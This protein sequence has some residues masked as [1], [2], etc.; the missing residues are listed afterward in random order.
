M[1]VSLSMLAGAGAQF[2]TDSGVPL[3]GGL[4][5][6]YL[7]GSTTPT[8]TWADNSGVTANANPIVLDAGGRV[9][10]EIWLTPGTDYK[11]VL[12]TSTGVQIWSK[13][14][15]PG[16]STDS[17]DLTFLQAGTGA[18]TRTVQSKLRDTVSVMD[19]GAVGDGVTDDTAAINAA[20]AASDDVF[21][22]AG[23]YKITST[24]S[25]PQRKSLRGV[26]YKSRLAATIASGAVISITSG[27]GPTEVSGFRITGTATTGVSVNN[28]QTLIVDNISLDG[29]TATDGFVFVSSW[30]SV[31][32]NL[33]TNGATLSDSCFTCGQDFNANDCRN[34]YA[35]NR[36]TYNV[37]IDGAYNGGSGV[38]HGST[39]T[40]LCVQSGL[41]GIY[42][43]SYQGGTVNGVYSEDVVFPLRLGVASTK[44]ARGMRF[45]GGDFGGPYNTHPSYSSREAVLW[46]DYA[47]GCSVDGIDLSGAYNCGNAAPITFSGGGGSGAFAIARVTAAGVVQSVEVLCGG[48]GYTSDP[49]ASVGGS[50][51]GA[52]LTVTRVGNS[53]STIAVSTAGSGYIASNCP[54]AVT[55]NRAFKC[56]V[57]SAM[58]NSSFGDSSPL[59][60]WFVRRSGANSGAGITLQNDTSWRNSANGNAAMMLKTRSNNY[61]HVLL[62]WD[63]LG[64]AQ[65]YVYT[66]PQYP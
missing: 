34:W 58:F 23:T 12:K 3:A 48:T 10:A 21:V 60:P 50:G 17:A 63:N 64:A 36:C 20:L 45:N 66:P 19:F 27:N 14:N 42:V 15:I 28:A 8:T 65:N 41:Y 59:Y 32:S 29:L 51:S 57:G 47:V 22:P 49:T 2:F 62:E 26:G 5:Y 38:S 30:G 16:L 46:F 53:V 33:W 55:Y 35:S 1:T 44:L 52:V 11:F 61:T 13:D 39:W 54:V 40:M 43:G 25:I 4:L 37:L 6:T 56:S 7:A 24:I 9:A 18:V 31:F